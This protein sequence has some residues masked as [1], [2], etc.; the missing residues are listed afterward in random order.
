[1]PSVT[2]I[3][4]DGRRQTV[5]IQIGKSVMQGAVLAGIDGIVAECGGELVCA[6]CHVFVQSG[7]DALS[8]K[9]SLEDEMLDFT[10]TPRRDTSRLSCQLKMTDDL[11]GLVVELPEAQI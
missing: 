5:E 7:T 8:E 9:S 4:P 10:A 6:T 3:H 11:D 2:F 1:M